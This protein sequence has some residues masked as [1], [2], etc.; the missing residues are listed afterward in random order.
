MAIGEQGRKLSDAVTPIVAPRRRRAPHRG[1][2]L[3]VLRS[4]QRLIHGGELSGDRTSENCHGRDADDG[5]ESHKQCVLDKS[6]ALLCRPSLSLEK[7][8]NCEL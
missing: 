3:L 8:E 2:G 7:P 5:Y 1:A 6:C 4:A